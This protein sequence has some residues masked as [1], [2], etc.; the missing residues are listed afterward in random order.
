MANHGGPESVVYDP[1]CGSGT[2]LIAAEQMSRRCRAIEINPTYVQ[3]AIDRW[4]AF[5]GRKVRKVGRT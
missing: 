3:M 1:F 5:T 4:E 2:A